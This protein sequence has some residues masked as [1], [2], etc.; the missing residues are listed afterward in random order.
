M[1]Q[2]PW[3]ANLFAASQ[4]I[5]HILW[6]PKVHYCI[7]KCS[8]PVSILSQ[9]HPVHTPTSHFL[10][11]HLNT[12]LPSMPGSPKWSLSLRF[13]HQN[14]V[15]TPPLL[16]LLLALC[17]VHLIL[18]N[19]ITQTILGEEYRSWSSS[20]CSFLHSFVTSFLL[21]PNIFLNI[22]FSNTLFCNH[23]ILTNFRISSPETL[24][25]QYTWMPSPVHQYVINLAVSLPIRRGPGVLMNVSVQEH[26]AP[27]N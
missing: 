13:P 8:P 2:S 24:Y 5:P 11:I 10:R 23:Q 17:P 20:L 3:E 15:Y 19:F 9:L 7:Q 25:I 22:L 18:L 1:E 6:Y 21:R 27:N 16:S 12:I 26:R 14:P 4:E